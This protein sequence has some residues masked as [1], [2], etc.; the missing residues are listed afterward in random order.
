MAK[1]H[2][3]KCSDTKPTDRCAYKYNPGTEIE[4]ATNWQLVNIE[5]KVGTVFK[6]P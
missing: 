2:T 6:S 5:Q 3:N 1:V 4:P